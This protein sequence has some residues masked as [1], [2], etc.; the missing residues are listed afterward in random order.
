MCVSMHQKNYD[1]MGKN[2]GNFKERE[3]E[4]KREEKEK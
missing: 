3:R 1:D 4:G 2:Y